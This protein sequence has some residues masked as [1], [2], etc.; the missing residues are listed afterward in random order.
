MSGG[1][2]L[3]G[4]FCGGLETNGV[5]HWDSISLD[6]S[7]CGSTDNEL[8]WG[9]SMASSLSISSL[10]LTIVDSNGNTVASWSSTQTGTTGASGTY[11]PC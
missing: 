1:W 11:Q 6:A 10:T 5:C 2:A 9:V 3:N 8:T 7:V 4:Y